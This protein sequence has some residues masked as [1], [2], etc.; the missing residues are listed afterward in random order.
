MSLDHSI[1]FHRPDLLRADEWMLVRVPWLVVSCRRAAF[2]LVTTN[3][4]AP[5]VNLGTN[6]RDRFAA[7]P[8]ND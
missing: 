8:V 4:K 5:L 6:L 3:K 1:H 7:G 2:F